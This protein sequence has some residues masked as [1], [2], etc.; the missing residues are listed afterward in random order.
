MDFY[1]CGQQLW[2]G[3][4]NFNKDQRLKDEAAGE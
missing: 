3:V 1:D 2:R 4:L